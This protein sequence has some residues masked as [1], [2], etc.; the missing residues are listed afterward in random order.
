MKNRQIKKIECY[1]L[2]GNV[3]S[4]N[5]EKIFKTKSG[6]YKVE[7]F[8]R[9]GNLIRENGFNEDMNED[10]VIERNF[11]DNN[12]LIEILTYKKY[13]NQPLS[14]T[15]LTK[16]VYKDNLLAEILSYYGTFDSTG[17]WA[18]KTISYNGKNQKTKDE[19]ISYNEEANKETR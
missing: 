9:N 12:N 4:N 15:Y 10:N 5:A 2:I 14:K 16:Y 17:F 6:L 8:D 1:A 18:R 19:Y 13:S 3:A 7:N 11:D